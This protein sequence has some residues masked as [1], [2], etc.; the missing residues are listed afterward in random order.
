MA[1]GSFAPIPDRDHPPL[2]QSINAQ[3]CLLT[4]DYPIR[5]YGRFLGTERRGSSSY[6]LGPPAQEKTHGIGIL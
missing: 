3:S 4:N 6:Y 1:E 5:L 2:G